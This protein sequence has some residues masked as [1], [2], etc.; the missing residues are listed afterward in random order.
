MKMRFRKTF[1]P[2]SILIRFEKISQSSSQY[3]IILRHVYPLI[4]FRYYR[5]NTYCDFQPDM[6]NYGEGIIAGQTNIY[7]LN[8]CFHV[9]WFIM[10]FRLISLDCYSTASFKDKLKMHMQNILIIYRYTT[11]SICKGSKGAPM[12]TYLLQKQ[13]SKTRTRRQQ[14]TI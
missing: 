9:L 6:S 13:Q 8:P 10:S 12:C 2:W 3:S 11:L 7:K 4:F 1:L 14:P 5:Q